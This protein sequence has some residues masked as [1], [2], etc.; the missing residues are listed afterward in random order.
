MLYKEL[1]KKNSCW[2]KFFNNVLICDDYKKSYYA[3]LIISNPTLIKKHSN[4]ISPFRKYKNSDDFSRILISI[5][6]IEQTEIFLKK[7]FTK[8]VIDILF[9]NQ[10]NKKIFFDLSF[11]LDPDIFNKIIKTKILSFNTSIEL[12]RFFQKI[13]V[14]HNKWNMDF[15][16]KIIN[17]SNLNVNIINKEH[18]KLIIEIKDYKASYFLG[19]PIWCISKQEKYYKQYNSSTDRLFFIYDFNLPQYNAK[20]ILGITIPNFPILKKKHCFDFYNDYSNLNKN[21]DFLQLYIFGEIFTRDETKERI[22][23]IQNYLDKIEQ[24]YENNF[25]DELCLILNQTIQ[26][27]NIDNMILFFVFILNQKNEKMMIEILS[28]I[29]KNKKSINLIEHTIADIINSFHYSFDLYFLS[30]IINIFNDNDFIINLCREISENRQNY[31]ILNYLITKQLRGKFDKEYIF[32]YIFK[33]GNKSILID[34]LDSGVFSDLNLTYLFGLF[35][36]FELFEFENFI[37]SNSTNFS[38]IKIIN[39]IKFNQYKR[40]NSDI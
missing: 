3:W 37:L 10:I 13:K 22:F 19:S 35:N 40:T 11:T 34:F 18:N 7:H 20:S 33:Y 26:E 27:K 2:L 4:L 16:L 29:E 8:K 39:R 21:K 32:S 25:Y 36:E 17:N 15:Y 28:N 14:H 24:L 1:L 31:N 23:S 5:I 30:E 38:N 6:H 12:L 9:D